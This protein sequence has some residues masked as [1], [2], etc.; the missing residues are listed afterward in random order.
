MP[1]LF[2]GQLYIGAPIFPFVLGSNVVQCTFPVLNL[3]LILA[4]GE[5]TSGGQSREL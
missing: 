5:S 4:L 3:T 1:E 2:K